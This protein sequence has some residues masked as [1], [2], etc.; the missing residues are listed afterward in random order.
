MHMSLS[1]EYLGEFL[2]V[3]LEFSVIPATQ[4]RHKLHLPGVL[5]VGFKGFIRGLAFGGIVCFEFLDQT[6]D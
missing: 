1:L 4:D 5:G 6:D 3:L 2:D